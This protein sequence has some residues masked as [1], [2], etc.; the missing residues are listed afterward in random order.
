M[1]EATVEHDTFVLER[2]YP[3][4]PAR[5]FAAFADPAAK[6]VWFTGSDD[7]DASE[8]ELDF[9]V[10]GREFT[11]GTAPNTTTVYT[12]VA[13]I[14]D[15]V[16][17]SRIIYSYYMLMD[18]KRISVSVTTVQLKAVPDGTQ[19]VLTEHGAFLDGLDKPEFRK[20]GISQ[21][22]NALGGLLEGASS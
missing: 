10:G 13:R 12:Y 21:Q 22:L 1:T 6:I 3:A 14:E 7:F 11:R 2:T 16:P 5:V 15:I 20:E 4:T 9:R 18:D 8:Y 19:L 17:D